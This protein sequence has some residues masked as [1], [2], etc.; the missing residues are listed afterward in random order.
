MDNDVRKDVKSLLPKDPDWDDFISAFQECCNDT[1]FDIKPKQS[2]KFRRNFDRSMNRDQV[3][4]SSTKVVPATSERRSSK[5]C[6]TC[7]STDPTHD[8]K[9]CKGKKKAI[10][11]VSN[12]QDHEEKITDY[13]E[14]E[15]SG[16]SDENNSG[17]NIEVIERF[18]EYEG[19]YDSEE[20]NDI[21]ITMIET[22]HNME[23]NI[24]QL[25]AET[26]IPQ[27]WD[28]KQVVQH[29]TDA[30]LLL[31]RPATGRAHM[32]GNHALTLVI[33]FDKEVYLLLDTGAA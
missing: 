29:V 5:A 14:Y 23:Q 16:S 12:I 6:Y 33:I 17:T 3:A 26:D 9:A 31:T 21:Q 19:S 13:M 30:R 27:L 22:L 28:R 2:S 32:V 1:S 8:W 10:N 24:A 4:G 25:Q 20:E 11:E 15:S 7:Q 18:S